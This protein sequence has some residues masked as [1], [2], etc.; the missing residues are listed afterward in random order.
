M[1]SDKKSSNSK[2]DSFRSIESD[3]K[4]SKSDDSVRDNSHKDI[5]DDDEIFLLKKINLFSKNDM[6]KKYPVIAIF[7]IL[8]GLIFIIT[9]FTS[10]LGGSEKVA[11]NVSLKDDGM[12][13]VLIG[14]V[15]LIIFGMSIFR[16]FARRSVDSIFKSLD[17]FDSI[18]F[19]DE[20]LS[21][22]QEMNDDSIADGVSKSGE[23]SKKNENNVDK[24]EGL[25]VPIVEETIPFE[26]S[27]TEKKTND[28]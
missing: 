16:L 9:A 17:G 10:L 20:N 5:L 23:N 12:F 4:F 25:N 27:E 19:N 6:K 24:H 3:E 7:G 21:S 11:D 2:L 26:V 22:K 8:L 14:F 28:D 15:G 1:S 13:S 18:K